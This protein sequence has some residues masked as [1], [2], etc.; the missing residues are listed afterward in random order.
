MISLR[1][2]I[3]DEQKV[4]LTLPSNSVIP[5][6]ILSV[7]QSAHSTQ[8]LFDDI[9]NA[10]KCR[11]DHEQ[12]LSFGATS[13][14]SL[15]RTLRKIQDEQKASKSVQNLRRMERFLKA[16]ENL[17]KLMQ[18][19]LGMPDKTCYIWGPAKLLLQVKT[20]VS[21]TSRIVEFEW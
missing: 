19:T 1:C 16:V 6:Q 10:F 15:K 12:W 13:A 18:E 5:S 7:V 2:K 3:T 21:L 14:G 9:L 20:S 8:A 17:D 11:F 4:N